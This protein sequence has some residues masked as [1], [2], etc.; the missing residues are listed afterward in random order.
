MPIFHKCEICGIRMFTQD[1]LSIHIA[2]AMVNDEHDRARQ[3]ERAGFQQHMTE[4]D[5]R[6]GFRQGKWAGIM[7][8]LGVLAGVLAVAISVVSLMAHWHIH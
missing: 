4:M 3:L 6:E 1:A 8:C 7:F 2:R 5:Y